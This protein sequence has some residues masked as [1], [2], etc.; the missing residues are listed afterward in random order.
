VGREPL[1]GVGSSIER[2]GSG[3]GL[4]E[5]LLPPVLE[6]KFPTAGT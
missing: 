3:L 4:L 1:R 2:L 5:T 6:R